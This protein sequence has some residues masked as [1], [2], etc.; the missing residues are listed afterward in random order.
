MFERRRCGRCGEEKPVDDFN[1]RR[2]ERG[3]RDNL[4]RPCRKA[5]HREHYLANKKTYVDQART[6]KQTLARERTGFLLE[7]FV[8]HPCVDCGET[9]PVVLEFDHLRDKAF[10]IGQALPYRAW[11]TIL[12]EIAKC[13]VVCANCHRRRTAR[14]AGTVRMRLSQSG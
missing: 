4:C 7:Y 2:K 8:E 1:W 13:E 14:R 5:Y 6:R 11:A 3:Q 12:E 10:D 9:D